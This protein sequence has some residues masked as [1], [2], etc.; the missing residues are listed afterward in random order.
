MNQPC[1]NDSCSEDYD[2]LPDKIAITVLLIIA[3]A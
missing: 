2:L 3:I 1:L